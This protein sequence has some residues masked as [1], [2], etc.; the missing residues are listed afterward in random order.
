MVPDSGRYVVTF[1][2]WHSVGQKPVVIYGEGGRL[3]AE[4]ILADLNLELNPKIEQS[5]SSYWWNKDAIMLF[6][7]PAPKD[8]EP[9]Q[10]TLENSLFIR[11]YW[12]EVLAID[13]AGGKLRDDRWWNTYPKDQ[14]DKLQKATSKY[15]DAAWHR[16]AGEYLRKSNFDPDPR[17]NGATG[18]LL[19]GQLH[20]R[21]A[22]PLLRELAATERFGGWAAPG[23]KGARNVKE[24]AQTAIN[25]IENSGNNP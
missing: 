1:D 24:L 10:R 5:V 22:L 21:E 2:E 8:A 7:P 18:I 14:K 19:A 16:L 25:E 4:L 12:G 3:I 17:A 20:L 9:W 6:G 15:L 11:L 23:W 13:L